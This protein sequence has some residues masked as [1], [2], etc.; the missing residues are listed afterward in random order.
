LLDTEAYQGKLFDYRRQRDAGKKSW[1][2]YAA[3]ARLRGREVMTAFQDG[4][5]DLTVLATFGPSLVWKQSGGGKTPM[6]DCADG[7]LVPF[8]DGMIEAA[9]GRTQLIDGFESSYGYR[10][11][12]AFAQAHDTITKQ[13]ATLAADRASYDRVLSAGFGLW[14]DYDWRHR[15]WHAT[16]VE[17]NYFSPARFETSLRAAIE[18]S[19]ELVWIYSETPRWWSEKGGTASLPTPYVEA[20]R[21][22]RSALVDD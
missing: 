13:A 9:R 6:A 19:D 21:R 20:I 12:A 18:Q 14:L 22:A 16:D 3:K 1:A 2:E 4:F 15:G 17:K 10:E 8:F 7:L 5:P 11:P